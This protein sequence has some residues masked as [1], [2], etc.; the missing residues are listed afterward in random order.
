[1][2]KQKMVRCVAEQFAEH[3]PIRLA[4]G[5]DLAFD[6]NEIVKLGFLHGSR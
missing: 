1:M 4:S 2:T 6:R 5:E 3:V